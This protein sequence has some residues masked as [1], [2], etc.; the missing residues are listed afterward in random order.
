M[1]I[2][3]HQS[4]LEFWRDG[5][6]EYMFLNDHTAS[7]VDLI[8]SH[9]LSGKRSEHD[10]MDSDKAGHSGRYKWKKMPGRGSATQ[11]MNILDKAI[12]SDT[13]PSRER[14]WQVLA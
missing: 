8:L 7:H 3:G 6:P 9:V 11:N 13:N 2:K 12:A 1:V 10:C 14:G 5:I 4:V